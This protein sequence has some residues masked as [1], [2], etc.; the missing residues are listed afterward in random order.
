M[1]NEERIPDTV[2]GGVC[3]IKK[4]CPIPGWECVYKKPTSVFGDLIAIND[5]SFL[6][7]L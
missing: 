1:C 3:M 7:A 2:S 5:M 4:G 6:G